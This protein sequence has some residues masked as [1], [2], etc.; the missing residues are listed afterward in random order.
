MWTG[1]RRA[2]KGSAEARWGCDRKAGAQARWE[3]DGM[4]L[5][6][7]PG[8]GE[9]G[10][11]VVIAAMARLMNDLPA[12][13]EFGWPLL[14]GHSDCAGIGYDVAFTA[15]RGADPWTK[16]SAGC[17]DLTVTV[18]ATDEYLYAYQLALIDPRGTVSSYIASLMR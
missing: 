4:A 16:V 17:Q 10:D 11:P 13:P 5:V 2:R 18:W 7:L 9:R 3:W 12:A 14:A 1:W 8:T 6:P 15:K